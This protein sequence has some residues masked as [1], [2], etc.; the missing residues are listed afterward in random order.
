M[1]GR[2]SPR[3]AFLAAALLAAALAAGCAAA[4][5]SDGGI[6]GTGDRPGC[7]AQSQKGSTS[8]ECE[9]DARAR[10]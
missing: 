10:K 5:K 2:P 1:S 7:E 9:P 4:P 8:P 3:S 6:V